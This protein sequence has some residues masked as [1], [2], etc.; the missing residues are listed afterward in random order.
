MYGEEDL[1]K[2]RLSFLLMG[3]VVMLLLTLTFSVVNSAP[4]GPALD[5]Y[6]AKG[7]EGPNQPSGAFNPGEEVYIY[8]LATYDGVG[9]EGKL[10]GFEVLD[11]QNASILQRVEITNQSGIAVL[12]FRIPQCGQREHIIGNWTVIAT[13]SIA[14]ETVTDTLVFNV[15]GTMLDLY[16]QRGG[17]G[18]DQPSDAFAPQ[19]EV[20]FYARVSFA[21][22]PIE[23]KLVAYE[24][25]DPNGTSVDYRAAETNASGIA[26]VAMRLPSAPIFGT[27]SA[28]ASVEVV[29]FIVNDTLTFKVGWIIEILDL[30]TT[31]EIG[32][33]KTDFLRGERIGFRFHLQNIA[34]SSEVATFT[35]N[36]YDD[37]HVPIGQVLLPNWMTPPNAS[38]IF[39]IGMEIPRWSYLGVGS[40]YANA[41]TE[42][43][44]LNGTAYCPEKSTQFQLS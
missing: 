38:M 33:P 34:F 14:E 5:I 22:D 39:A 12:F 10:V 19:E 31:D 4:S 35:L 17:K 1:N 6:T 21:C 42:P 41:F 9:V 24:V 7:G 32:A 30:Q 3:K 8:A 43:P 28:V 36:V 29:G 15:M 11:P 27:W 44:F 40:V 26:V 20:I 23:N 25:F 37:C 16:T 2:R 13:V 18:P